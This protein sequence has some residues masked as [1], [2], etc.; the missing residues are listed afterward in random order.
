[1]N[2]LMLVNKVVPTG[3]SGFPMCLLSG[4][5]VLEP[6]PLFRNVPEGADVPIDTLPGGQD[7]FIVKVGDPL[8]E[9]ENQPFVVSGG[10]VMDAEIV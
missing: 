4:E 3:K 9:L 2:R 7:P 8:P 5:Y 6:R 10:S 1:M